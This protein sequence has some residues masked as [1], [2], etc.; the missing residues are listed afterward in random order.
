LDGDSVVTVD[1]RR[2][3][4]RL[5]PLLGSFSRLVEA[6][7]SR[8]VFQL[9]MRAAYSGFRALSMPEIEAEWSET[10]S[11]PAPAAILD[12][13]REWWARYGQVHLYG[14]L[15]LLEIGDEG[16]LQELEATTSLQQR[17]LAKLSPTL[18][19]V[20]DDAVNSLLAEMTAKGYRPREVR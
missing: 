11:A 12:Q 1:P 14:G 4:P 13:L 5:L 19:V 8:Y 2:A 9:D 10:V 18:L 6:S 20:P 15:A 17:V 3:P 7:P 16:T